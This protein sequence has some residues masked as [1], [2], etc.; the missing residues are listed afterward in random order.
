[1]DHGTEEGCKVLKAKRID[2]IVHNKKK[3]YVFIQFGQTNFDS[4]SE[5][6]MIN[7][8]YKRLDLKKSK[9]EED[10]ANTSE[11]D[12]SLSEEDR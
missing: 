4:A 3:G 10:L 11:G 7:M 2:F 6:K 12:A 9:M 8:L 1:M 5:G